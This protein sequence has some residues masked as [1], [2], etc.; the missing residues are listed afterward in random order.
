MDQWARYESTDACSPQDIFEYGI[1]DLLQ[2]IGYKWNDTIRLHLDNQY[3]CIKQRE[4][5]NIVLFPVVPM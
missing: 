1:Y 2:E 4:E 5:S 3:D